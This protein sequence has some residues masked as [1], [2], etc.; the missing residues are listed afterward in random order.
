MK[1]ENQNILIVSNEP[2]GDVWYSKHNWAY[3]LSKKNRVVFINPPKP[4]VFK[5][6]FSTKISTSNYSL[7]LTI[8]NYTNRFPFTRFEF[9]SNINELLISQTIKKWLKNNVVSDYIFWTFDPY[10]FS[11]PKQFQPKLTIY[12]RVDKYINDREKTL[13]KNT[14]KLVVVSKELLNDI[15]FNG[16]ILE[17]SHGISE[18]E[19]INDNTIEY[20]KDFILYIGNI[21][22][23]LDVDLIDKMLVE[24]P[25]EIFLFIGKIGD[26]K[27]DLFHEIF[28]KNKHKNLILHGAEYFKTLKNYIAQAK[29]CIAPMFLEVNGNNIN[30]HKLLQ[31]LALGRPVLAPQF[32]DYQNNT[33]VYS[34]KNHEEGVKQLNKILN[35]EEN[36]FIIKERII[37]AKQFTYNNL[38]K[39]VE[40][41]L[42]ESAN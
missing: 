35:E 18:E 32:I 26:V 22:H 20:E 30:H 8:L 11:S 14:D 15:E 31:Y 21:D 13:L 38:I 28:L 10:R 19:F 23:R 9:L 2:W 29:V 33:L 4:W 6:L 25:E 42:T 40:Q 41:F 39:K 7:T 12:F 37:F 16:A 34:Y 3:E 1:L 36:Q 24:F 27:N 5:N 17:L